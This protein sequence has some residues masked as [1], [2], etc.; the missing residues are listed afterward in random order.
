MTRFLPALCCSLLLS[1]AAPVWG[2]AAASGVETVDIDF[3]HITIS[4]SAS[5]LRVSG[6]EGETLHIYNV[7][8]VRVMSVAIDSAD[9]RMELQLPKGCYILKVGKCVRKIS[10]R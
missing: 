2:A 1:V 9:K 3:Q 8:G 4:Y 7:A 5:V 10:C 6:A